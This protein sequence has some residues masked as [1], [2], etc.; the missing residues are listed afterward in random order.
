MKLLMHNKF[1]IESTSER[2]QFLFTYH[3]KN[4]TESYKRRVLE[5]VAKNKPNLKRNRLKPSRR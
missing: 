1:E 5:K 4:D 3:K 2:T